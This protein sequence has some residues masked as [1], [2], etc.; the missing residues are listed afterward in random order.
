[1]SCLTPEEGADLDLRFGYHKPANAAIVKMHE[2]AR[3]AMGAA[4][5]VVMALVPKGRE[6]ALALT[7]L[8]E[9]MMWANAGIARALSAEKP[10]A[11]D[12][13]GHVFW[14]VTSDERVDAEA[15]LL[16]LLRSPGAEDYKQRVLME[17]ESRGFVAPERALE[18]D[19]P[20][21]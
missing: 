7:K 19:P 18:I 3:G 11:S 15:A 13:F 1:M 20:K 14:P 5:A 2:E 9:A 4:A 17:L 16:S 6:Q 10:V 12:H 21:V 8:E